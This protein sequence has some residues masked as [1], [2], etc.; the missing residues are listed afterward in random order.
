ML[1][2]WHKCNPILLFRLSYLSAT[3]H[4]LHLQD[5]LRIHRLFPLVN[6]ILD[7]IFE[8]SANYRPLKSIP[9]LALKMD[10]DSTQNL[11]DTFLHLKNMQ[12]VLIAID[13]MRHKTSLENRVKFDDSA[14]ST[15]DPL[16]EEFLVHKL[17]DEL[18]TAINS[19]FR[20]Y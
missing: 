20:W 16:S 10:N 8:F 2:R 14:R 13:S 4:H 18:S 3:Y 17:S 6:C 5:P 11:K 12:G 7:R 1:Y 19:M 15:R 9:F